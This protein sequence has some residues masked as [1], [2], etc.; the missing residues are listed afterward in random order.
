MNLVFEFGLLQRS[1]QQ[2]GVGDFERMGKAR[3]LR[4]FA[5]LIVT[6][7]QPAKNTESAA[8]DSVECGLNFMM[9]FAGF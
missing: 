1:E 5:S 3:Q 8:I 4:E 7:A 2:I 9:D 6:S